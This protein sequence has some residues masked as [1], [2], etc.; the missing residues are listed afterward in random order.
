MMAPRMSFDSDTATSPLSFDIDEE[1]YKIMTATDIDGG[2]DKL[3]ISNETQIRSL[4][5]SSILRPWTVGA[6]Q[7]DACFPVNLRAYQQDE[8]RPC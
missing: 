8:R 2:F 1:Y 3:V 7:R 6:A 4:N 5:L